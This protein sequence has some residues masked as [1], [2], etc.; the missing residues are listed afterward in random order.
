MISLTSA[1]WAKYR[2]DWAKFRR[3][4]TKVLVSSHEVSYTKKKDKI[5]V[6]GTYVLTEGRQWEKID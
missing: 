1:E 2:D 4:G 6:V 5:K 3:P